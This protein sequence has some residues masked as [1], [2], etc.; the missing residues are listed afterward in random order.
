MG[1]DNEAGPRIP[2]DRQGWLMRPVL[3]YGESVG[4]L[5]STQIEENRWMADVS[6]RETSEVFSKEISTR[7]SLI[8]KGSRLGGF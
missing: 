6:R 8:S 4:S 1:P 5:E 2:D 7:K 3:G